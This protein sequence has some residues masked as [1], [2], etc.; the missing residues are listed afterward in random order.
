V[1]DTEKSLGVACRSGCWGVFGAVVGIVLCVQFIRYWPISRP[2]AAPYNDAMVAMNIRSRMCRSEVREYPAVS[3]DAGVPHISWEVTLM[4]DVMGV[5]EEES[6]RFLNT[7]SELLASS[8]DPIC[9]SVVH[10]H[11]APSISYESIVRA[12]IALRSTGI[13]Y[14][15]IDGMTVSIAGPDRDLTLK[16]NNNP[17]SD[18]SGH[19]D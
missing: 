16:A 18:S 8:A 2:T 14:V 13:R 15:L 5:N 12:L 10:L 1:T 4:G 17:S 9:E 19:P 3:L 6:L 7:Y 11:I